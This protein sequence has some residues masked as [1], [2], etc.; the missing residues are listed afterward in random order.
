MALFLML[1]EAGC[2]YGLDGLV[3]AATDTKLVLVI[4]VVVQCLTA[5]LSTFST[6]RNIWI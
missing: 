4:V 3:L 5:L 6:P 2:L 1:L